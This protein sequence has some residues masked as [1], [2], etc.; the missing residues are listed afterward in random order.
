MSDPACG[1]QVLMRRHPSSARGATAIRGKRLHRQWFA[2]CK[3]CGRTAGAQLPSDRMR[4]SL[5]IVIAVVLT[6]VS[7]SAAAETLWPGVTYET[8]LQLTPHGPVAINILIGPRPGGTTTL[9]P[10]L[11]GDTLGGRET[12]TAMQRRLSSTATSA[13][14][15][16]DFFSFE[17][18]RPSGVVLRDTQVLAPPNRDRSSA[19]I[20]TDGTL[21]IR[22]IEFYGTW[23]GT[24]PARTLT[25]LNEAP[26][27]N[28]MALFTQVWG[29]STPPIAGSTAVTLFPLPAVVPNTD[30]QAPAVNVGS[31]ASGVQ[32]PLGGGVL[33]ARGTAATRVA[34]ELPPGMLATLRVIFRP[35]WPGVVSA[36][37]G[38]PQIVRDGVPVFRANEQFTTAQLNP[39]TSRTGFG[40]LADGR[41]ILVAVDGNQPGHSVGMTNFE[42]AQALVRL[43]AVTGMALDGGGSTTMAFDGALLNRP[44][45]GSERSVSDALMFLYTGVYLPPTPAVVSPNNDGIDDGPKMRYRV[46][47]PSTVTVTVRRPDGSFAYR[48]TLARTPGTYA[49]SFPPPP[50]PPPAPP[51]PPPA[52]VPPPAPAPPVAPPPTPAPEPTP[53]PPGAPGS[54]VEPSVTTARTL[55]AK[56]ARPAAGRW[57]FEATAVDDSGQQSS[58][59]RSYV[60]NT[61]LGFLR[62]RPGRLYLP[63]TGRDLAITWRVGSEA[64][65]RVTVETPA[66]EV[67]RLLA[68]RRYPVGS[69]S[70]VWNGLD[71]ARGPVKGGRYVVRVVARNALG[72]M[73]LTRVVGVQRVKR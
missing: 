59:S 54:P 31:G 30:V 50:S 42:L 71:R 17:T 60:V 22:K 65:T 36:I 26:P 11:S 38:G 27:Q 46:V 9:A 6:V 16:G 10:V 66:G 8:G 68:D 62:T 3:G 37:G 73:E 1:V 15:N 24:G 49:L 13:G 56:A 35:D 55:A 72:R 5:L 52:P 19:G 18:G 4:R 21:D 28:G 33:I 57:T 63:P 41:I 14:V 40:Q 12:V 51:A 23:R 7:P 45:G 43:G 70:V 69:A 58:M 47:R 53:P 25:T 20:L 44:S 67:I 34:Q 32:I 64:R 61:T 29:G 2:S 48:A 39:R